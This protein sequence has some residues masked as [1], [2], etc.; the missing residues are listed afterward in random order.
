MQP[1]KANRQAREGV[2]WRRRF[3]GWAA[4]VSPHRSAN[5]VAAVNTWSAGKNLPSFSTDT[6]S[7]PLAAALRRFIALARK[8]DVER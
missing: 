5:L 6:T 2:Q 4:P 1:R 3:C 8:D 7:Q